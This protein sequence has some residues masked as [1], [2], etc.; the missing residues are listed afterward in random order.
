MGIRGWGFDDVVNVVG[1]R[2]GG[3]LVYSVGCRGDAFS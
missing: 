2:W 3:F 1:S